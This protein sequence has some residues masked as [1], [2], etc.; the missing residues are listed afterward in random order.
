MTAHDRHR[1]DSI[2]PA[3]GRWTVARKIRLLDM[4]STGEITEPDALSRYGVTGE[5]LDSWARRYRR[6]GERGL[7]ATQLQETRS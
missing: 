2:P 5:E 6:F 3:S 4:I 1:E 7:K